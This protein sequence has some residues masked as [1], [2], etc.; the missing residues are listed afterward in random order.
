VLGIRQLCR[1]PALARA[2][3]S[4]RTASSTSD[5]RRQVTRRRQGR[6]NGSFKSQVGGDDSSSVVRLG[7]APRD[8]HQARE[9]HRRGARRDRWHSI[10]VP[11][12]IENAVGANRLAAA[13]AQQLCLERAGLLD[14][15]TQ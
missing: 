6:S 1:K 14:L 13:I 8:S 9:I 3:D 2:A 12:I 10:G 5:V 15:E 11:D 7:C 4:A